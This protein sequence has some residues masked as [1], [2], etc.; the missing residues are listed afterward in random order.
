VLIYASRRPKLFPRTFSHHELFHVLVIAG[1]A[2]HFAAIF[3][4]AIPATV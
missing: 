2:F 1:S 4:Y 3:I